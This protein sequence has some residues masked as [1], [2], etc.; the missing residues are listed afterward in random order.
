MYQH[1]FSYYGII[2]RTT[3]KDVVCCDQ[4]IFPEINIETI[5]F[6]TIFLA[7]PFLESIIEFISY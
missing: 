5:S 1:V 6:S 7:K 4:A 3:F 2:N